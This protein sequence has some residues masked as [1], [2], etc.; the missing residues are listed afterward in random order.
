MRNYLFLVVLVAFA[1][2]KSTSATNNLSDASVSNETAK[3]INNVLDEFCQEFEVQTTLNGKSCTC[4][5]RGR[6]DSVVSFVSSET[7]GQILYAARQGL[8][9]IKSEQ[10][11]KV[12]ADFGSFFRTGDNSCDLF[13]FKGYGVW[14]ANRGAKDRYEISFSLPLLKP[15]LMLKYGSMEILRRQMQFWSDENATRIL[16]SRRFL[17]LDFDPSF[18][19]LSSEQ[20]SVLLKSLPTLFD[21]AQNIFNNYRTGPDGTKA[22]RINVNFGT[23]DDQVMTAY[24]NNVRTFDMYLD[25]TKDP[26]NKFRNLALGTQSHAWRTVRID[27]DVIIVPY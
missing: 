14:A 15:D 18:M 19:D 9:E 23:F 8:R 5:L 4:F 1:S 22:D 12:L 27:R 17:A 3:E 2:C 25:V 13:L 6:Y 20:F 7:Q 24:R 10:G 21:N 11:K 16:Q 26:A